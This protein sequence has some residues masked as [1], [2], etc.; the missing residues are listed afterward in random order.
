MEHGHISEGFDPVRDAFLKNFEDGNELGAGFA[1]YLNGEWL[2]DIY[3][4]YA[5]RAKDQQ[6]TANTLVPVY[7]T[8]KGIS[9]LVLG[10]LI[11]QSKTVTY[12]SSVSELWPEFGA[13]GKEAITIA[14]VT[15][16]QAGLPGFDEEIDPAIWLDPSTCAAALAECPPMWE[17]G[18]AHGYHPLSWGYLVGEIARRLDPDGLSRND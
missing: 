2:V 8:T 16:H 12:D 9:A 15:S 7:S 11:G 4:G 1:V 10:W 18:T 3:G 14:E 5:D 17:P 6:W 13:N